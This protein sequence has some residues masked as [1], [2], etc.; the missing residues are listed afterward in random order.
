MAFSMGYGGLYN[1]SWEHN[2]FWKLRTENE[3]ALIFRASKMIEPGDEIL[4]RY[5]P[6]WERLW[7]DTGIE[8]HIDNTPPTFGES[9]ASQYNDIKESVVSE[10]KLMSNAVDYITN[11]K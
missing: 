5:N 11:K 1:H 6:D 10:D 9:M 4:I 8:R 7:F 2:A 3:P